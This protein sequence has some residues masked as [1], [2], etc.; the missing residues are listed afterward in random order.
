MTER[1]NILPTCRTVP[2]LRSPS[3]IPNHAHNRSRRDNKRLD[4]H[5]S[6]RARKAGTLDRNPVSP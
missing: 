5:V 3:D 4:V 1:Q 6:P 2:P